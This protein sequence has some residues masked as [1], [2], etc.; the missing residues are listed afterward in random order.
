[1]LCD[2]LIKSG[3]LCARAAGDVDLI[4]HEIKSTLISAQNTTGPISAY[5][6]KL[7]P[8]GFS[9]GCFAIQSRVSKQVRHGTR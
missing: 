9:T 1:M 5:L 3:A 7:Y 2:V 6:A 4:Q 8:F